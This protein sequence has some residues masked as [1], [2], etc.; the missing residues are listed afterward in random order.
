MIYV[1]IFTARVVNIWNSLLNSVAEANSVNVFKA[2][3]D[4]FW[5][6]QTVMFDFTANLSGTGNQS[7]QSKSFSLSITDINNSPSCYYT[8]MISDIL[9]KIFT[10]SSGSAP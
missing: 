8:T 7:V 10:T 4:K 6:H 2:R 9:Y 1:N 5:L 3:L